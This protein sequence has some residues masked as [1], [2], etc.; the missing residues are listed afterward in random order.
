MTC[1]HVT[2][3][4]RPP[5]PAGDG[6]AVGPVLVAVLLF[7]LLLPTPAMGQPASVQ[8][9]IERGQKAGADADLMQTVASRAEAAGIG[10]QQAADLLR[11]AVTLAERDLPTR[12]LLNKTL[13]GLAKR[14]PPAR[15]SPVLQRLQSHTEQA[16]GLVSGWM[17]RNEVQRLVGAS[18]EDAAARTQLIT[19]VTETQQQDVPLSAVQQ[20]LDGLP[21]K[22][23]GQ[24][25][26]VNQ[27]ATAVSIMPD[28]PGGKQ[29]PAVTSQLLTAA[30][31]AG[32]DGESL[33]QLP[34]ALERAQRGTQRPATAIAKGVTQAIAKGTPAAS[35]LRS[36]F[37]GGMPGG[38]APSEVG[39]GPPG[40][41]PGQGKPPGQ[42]G[43]PPGTGPPDDP[44][45]GGGPPDEPGGD[46]PGGDPGG[47]GGG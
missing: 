37:Q 20:F 46:P 10:A 29:N 2:I 43:K 38:G 41:P 7:A 23:S 4:T 11:P 32:Y 22:M 39:N 9:L 40:A 27:V 24:S 36:L 31:N 1:S 8:S 3:G 18:G 28:V 45:Q 19:N 17:K 16:G 26:S 15:M 35:V 14:V 33:R 6:T 42:G 30:L 13:E 12:P 25:V 5:R 47:G 44:G 34:A 21:E